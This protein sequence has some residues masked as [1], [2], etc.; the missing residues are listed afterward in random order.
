MKLMIGA[1]L[2]PTQSNLELFSRGDGEALFGKALLSRWLDADFRIFDLE[3]PFVDQGTP[4]EKC[5]PAIFAP[6]AAMAGVAALE[7][8]LV[9]L[10]NNHI[11]DY[12]SEGLTSTCSLLSQ[13][14]IPFVGVGRNCREAEE[15]YYFEEDGH[16]VVI[17]ACAEREFSQAGEDTPGA[18]PFDPLEIADTLRAIKEDCDTLIV[19]YHGGPEEWPYPTPSLQKRLRKM[20]LAG[21]DAVF[22]QHGHCV[23]CMEEYEGGLILYGQGNLLFDV[24]DGKPCW[25]SGLVVELTLGEGPIKAEYLPIG[26]GEGGCRLLE[27]E[28]ETAVLSGFF[29]RSEEIKTPGVVE[30]RTRERA[31]AL[32]GQLGRALLG[33]SVLLRGLN[34]LTGRKPLER[35]YDRAARLRLFNFFA[36]ET[37]RELYLTELKDD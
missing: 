5:G 21:A 17:Y 19:L 36:C 27:G 16:R 28:E 32:S 11:M 20:I 23:G 10:A 24:P 8:S 34:V 3:C 18:N 31:K 7:P 33:N 13:M 37:L 1:D 4:I 35:F 26:R 14:G 2:A 15:P 9:T 12:G 6:A 29:A 30:A 25:D 22:C